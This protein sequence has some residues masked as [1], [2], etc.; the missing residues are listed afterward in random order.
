VTEGAKA[1][2][3]AK[4]KGQAK[5]KGGAKANGKANA[6]GEVKAPFVAYP[7]LWWECTDQAVTR[8]STVR[9]PYAYY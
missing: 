2:G 7:D 1:K 8:L 3:E 6:Q 5:A 9:T 4:A